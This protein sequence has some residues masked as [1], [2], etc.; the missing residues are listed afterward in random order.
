MTEPFIDPWAPDAYEQWQARVKDKKRNGEVCICGHS[1]KYHKAAS[2]GGQV[3]CVPGRTVCECRTPRTALI[4]SD[5]RQFMQKTE[6]TGALH[7]LGKGIATG[8]RK[9]VTMTPILTACDDCHRETAEGF[10]VAPAP[11]DSTGRI[12]DVTTQW[13]LLLC[14][15]CG[16]KR[17]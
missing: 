13:N 1:V 5:L 9:G 10:P 3:F 15:D 4:V 12:T 11:I 6:G 17:G 16:A 8:K 14:R 7:A 2:T